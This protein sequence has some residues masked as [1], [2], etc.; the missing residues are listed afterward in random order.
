[1]KGSQYAINTGSTFNALNACL[2]QNISFGELYIAGPWSAA[3]LQATVND[4][5]NSVTIEGA[6]L[7]IYNAA[8]YLTKRYNVIS[9]STSTGDSGEI[10]IYCPEIPDESSSQAPT[11]TS[12]QA[13][14]TTP[15]A[16][17]TPVPGM[18]GDYAYRINSNTLTGF[19]NFEF[20]MGGTEEYL[21]IH[22]SS[23]S[24]L[25]SATVT[26]NGVNQP[27]NNGFYFEHTD[28]IV[29]LHLNGLENDD[30]HDIT[31]TGTGGTISF[32]LK[33]GNPGTQAVQP[34]NVVVQNKQMIKIVR[35]LHTFPLT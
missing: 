5:A 24:G 31:V 34:T 14:T 4:E 29:G 12:T 9:V 16:G 8:N 33:K 1:M 10:I 27:Y 23:A 30:Y 3:G 19:S 20:Y 18:S 35:N 21:H 6:G 22:G 17:W 2:Y 25:A 28:D 11:Q 15:A 32:T 13:P 7:R 26:L